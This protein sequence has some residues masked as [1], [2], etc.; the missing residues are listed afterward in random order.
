LIYGELHWLESEIV[1]LGSKPPTRDILDR[2]KRLEERTSR[3][4]VAS[5]YMPMLY[6][7]KDN[8]GTVRAKLQRPG[9]GFGAGRGN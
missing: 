5:K 7:L 2:M 8:I 9:R 1:K 3:V 6:T 4:R